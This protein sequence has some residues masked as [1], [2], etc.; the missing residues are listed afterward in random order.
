MADPTIISDRN[1]DHIVGKITGTGA[2]LN[3]EI[4]FI[5]SRVEIINETN[6]AKFSWDS[7]MTDGYAFKQITNG[8]LSLITTGGIS[9]YAGDDDDSAG[10]SLGTDAG[11]NA[12]NDVIRFIAFR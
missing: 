10:F 12:N 2:A 5:P 4:G 11:L 1:A 6:L 8:T 9:D 3:V 7:N